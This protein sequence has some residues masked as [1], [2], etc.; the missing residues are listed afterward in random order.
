MLAAE[1][2]PVFAALGDPTRLALFTRLADGRRRSIA[3]L[4]ADTAMTRQAITKHLRVLENAGLVAS[5]RAGRETQFAFRPEPIAEIRGY[6][7]EVSRQW[8]DALGRLKA[9]VEG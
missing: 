8:D 7:D 1:A 3:R 4:S 2:A 5:T 6:L 9:F